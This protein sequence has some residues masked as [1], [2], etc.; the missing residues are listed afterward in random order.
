[1]Y[2]T[3]FGIRPKVTVVLPTPLWVPAITMPLAGREFISNR[4]FASRPSIAL[5]ISWQ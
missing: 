2:G 5:R 3:S 4:I 1:M